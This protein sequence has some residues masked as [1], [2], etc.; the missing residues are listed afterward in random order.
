MNLSNILITLAVAYASYRAAKKIGLP[1]PAM[2]GSM[3][4][5]GISNL[6]FDYAVMPLYVKTFAQA[7]S[8]AFIGM[9]ITKKDLKNF[10][11]LVKP[12]L[13]LVCVLTV[14][15]FFTGVLMHVLSGM[16]YATALLG[17]VAGG[18][19]DISL[20]SIDMHANTPIVALLQTARLVGVLLIFPYWIKFFTRNEKDADKDFHL[21]TGSAE[22][23]CTFLDRLI[24]SPRRKIVFTILVSILFGGL[25]NISRIPAGAMVFPMLAVIALNVTTSACYVPIQVKNVAQLLAGTLVG[26]SIT[27]SAF[28]DIGSILVPLILLLINY[29]LVNLLYSLYCKKRGL[30]DLKSAMFAS[31]PGGATDMSLIAADLNAD[32]TKIALIQVLR[33]IYAVTLMPA[34]IVLFTHCF[35]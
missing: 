19:S 12:F 3:I 34:L 16:D 1:A 7:I 18:V 23:G 27:R 17:C 2:I 8:G 28:A 15:T 10:R 20:I 9:Q 29:W 4:G 6:F 22:N 33:A 35:H 5:V 25:G 13:I 31:A 14:N 30:L 24:N 11:Y 21:V 32:L 26:C